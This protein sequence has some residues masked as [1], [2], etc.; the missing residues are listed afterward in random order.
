MSSRQIDTGTEDLLARAANRVRAVKDHGVLTNDSHVTRLTALLV[1]IDPPRI[2]KI[3]SNEE[4]HQA[5]I[6]NGYSIA[7]DLKE[8]F[9]F[10]APIVADSGNGC[11]LLYKIDLPVEDVHLVKDVLAA[12]RSG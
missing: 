12:I 3:S 5:A 9:D 10:P 1:D 8:R 7:R 2:S 11:H 4:E 6:R